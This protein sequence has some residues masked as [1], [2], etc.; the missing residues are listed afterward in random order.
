MGVVNVQITQAE[1]TNQV[2]ADLALS[3]KAPEHWHGHTGK[4]D[5]RKHVEGCVHC[6]KGVSQRLGVALCRGHDLWVPVCLE[7]VA[8]G[9]HGDDSFDEVADDED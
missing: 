5:V 9:H 3:L 8:V 4:H 1:D 6:A 7:R 2:E